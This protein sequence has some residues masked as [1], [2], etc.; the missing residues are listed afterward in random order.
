MM[1][2][3]AVR[4]KW[5]VCIDGGVRIGSY[6]VV[7]MVLMYMVLTIEMS[8]WYKLVHCVCVLADC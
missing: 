7:C 4:C 3:G 5:I 1:I 2:C 6:V 8:V